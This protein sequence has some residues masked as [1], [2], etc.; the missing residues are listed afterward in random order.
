[1]IAVA[2]ANVFVAPEELELVPI[3]P[4]ESLRCEKI[5]N[6]FSPRV[7]AGEITDPEDTGVGSSTGA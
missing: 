5:M 7:A 2:T 1:M 6:S 3:V 4:M